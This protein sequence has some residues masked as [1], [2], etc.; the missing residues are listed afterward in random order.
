MP[1]ATV[2]SEA[3]MDIEGQNICIVIVSQ[4]LQVLQLSILV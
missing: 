3:V 1:V 4:L 2:G